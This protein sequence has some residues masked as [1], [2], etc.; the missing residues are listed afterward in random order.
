MQQAKLHL[1]IASD[2]LDEGVSLALNAAVDFCERQIGRSLRV[3]HT[4]VQS[5]SQWPCAP[6]RFDW[7]PAYTISH[8][9][10][11]N[12]DNTLTTVSSSDYRL[13][14]GNATCSLEFG[15][16]FTFPS[17][18]DRSDAVQITYLAGYATLTDVPA[19]AKVAVLLALSLDWGDLTPQQA[20]ETQRSL[21]AKLASVDPGMYR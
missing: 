17:L 4:V 3:A 16:D 14:P 19:A 18:Y 20:V 15:Q 2:D 7:Q 6:V 21:T 8:I 13:I 1:R 5:Y 12:A 11:Y 9:K 10:Y